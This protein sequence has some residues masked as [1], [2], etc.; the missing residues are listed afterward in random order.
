MTDAAVYSKLPR[1]KVFAPKR[2][3]EAISKRRRYFPETLPL[4]PLVGP[5]A[6]VLPRCVVVQASI[7]AAPV[8]PCEAMFVHSTLVR[9][10]KELEAADMLV[11]RV[12]CTSMLRPG[13]GS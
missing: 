8:K 3:E 11:N 6:L 10:I 5:T 4:S 13:A 9:P 2:V 7:H 1:A 12:S